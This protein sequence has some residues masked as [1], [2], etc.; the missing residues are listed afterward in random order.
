MNDKTA[1]GIEPNTQTIVIVFPEPK[2]H[3]VL[4]PEQAQALANDLLEKV[5]ILRLQ[6]IN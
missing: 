1:I 4:S 3:L 6:Q 5:K 2:T